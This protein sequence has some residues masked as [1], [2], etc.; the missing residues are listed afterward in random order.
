MSL[1]RPDEVLERSLRCT[2]TDSVR[3]LIDLVDDTGYNSA[4]VRFTNISRGYPLQFSR[5]SDPV[6]QL[7]GEQ[8]YRAVTNTWVYNLS[9]IQN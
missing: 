7:A 6:A 3:W 9:R 5:M 2:S 8:A 1:R 4:A